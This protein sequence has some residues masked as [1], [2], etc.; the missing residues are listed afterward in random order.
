MET[1]DFDRFMQAAL[2]FLCSTTILRSQNFANQ[3]RT[4]NIRMTGT[5]K[6]GTR[7]GFQFFGS[8]GVMAFAAKVAQFVSA[9]QSDAAHRG[10]SIQSQINEL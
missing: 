2:F 9:P 6:P 3:R 1:T 7:P 5:K 4:L 10:T 8:G